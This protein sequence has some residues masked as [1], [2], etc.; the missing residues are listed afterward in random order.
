M[1]PR[2]Y[3]IDTLVG[4]RA[5]EGPHAHPRVGSGL[6]H[7]DDI[8]QHGMVQQKAVHWAITTLDKQLLKTT[9]VETFYPCF[10]TVATTQELDIGVRMIG[11]HV[12]DFVV[13]AF[14]EVVAIFEVGF[15]DFGFI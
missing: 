13:E 9:L 6:V 10:A 7:V 14:V 1:T 12:D 11:K 5:H 15:A 8:L 3:L 2:V 4:A